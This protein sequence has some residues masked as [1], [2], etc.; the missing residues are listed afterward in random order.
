MNADL[1]PDRIVHEGENG[2][3]VDKP[4]GWLTVPGRGGADT[5]VLGTILQE[6]FGRLWPVHRLD[7]EVSGL[8]LFARNAEAHKAACAWFEGREVTKTYE[9]ITPWVGGRKI[10]GPQDWSMKLHRGKKRAYEADHG[11]VALTQARLLERLDLGEAPLAR[12]E[13]HPLTG[14]SHQL[15]VALAKFYAPICG[16]ELYGG[17]AVAALALGNEAIALRA[18]ALDFSAIAEKDRF[19]LPAKLSV[20]GLL[21]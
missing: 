13:L 14:R 10:E 19:G 3:V 9:A 12:W 20:K 16:D 17:K 1:T 8:V 4:A 21:P 15:R 2:L 5:P 18:V 11:Q 6:R 7:R